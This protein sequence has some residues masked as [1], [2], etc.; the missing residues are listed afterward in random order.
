MIYANAYDAIA[1]SISHNEATLCEP[2]EA[3]LDILRA[4]ADDYVDT[5]DGY[6]FW[7]DALDSD[8]TDG[9]MAWRVEIRTKEEL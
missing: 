7:S 5:G 1:R 6:D 2:T 8:G 3:N 4:E 9:K